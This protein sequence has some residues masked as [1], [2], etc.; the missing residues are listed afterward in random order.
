MPRFGKNYTPSGSSNPESLQETVNGYNNEGLLGT[1]IVE[2]SDSKTGVKYEKRRREWPYD[3]ADMAH[4]EEGFPR[5]FP[6]KGTSFLDQRINETGRQQV[7]LDWGCAKGYAAEEFGKKYGDKILSV[8]YS[9]DSYKNWAQVEHAVLI[10]ST[11]DQLF[12]ELKVLDRKIDLVYSRVSLIYLFPGA[13]RTQQ[14]PMER[15]VKYMER[16]L[17]NL[18]DDGVIAFDVGQNLAPEITDALKKALEGKAEIILDDQNLEGDHQIYMKKLPPV[19]EVQASKISPEEITTR[20]QKDNVE[21]K[22]IRQKMG[23]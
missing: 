13:S 18:S 17:E 22:A 21:I 12:D 5:L 11:A 19:K 10:Q 8:G 15:G 20:Q 23:I 4:I 6:E 7:I 2:D 16:L 1:R 14:V 3:D 9:M